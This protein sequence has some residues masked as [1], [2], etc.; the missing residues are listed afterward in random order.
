[1]VEA[2]KFLDHP[3]TKYSGFAGVPL[4]NKEITQKAAILHQ[5]LRFNVCVTALQ[6]IQ[7]INF[8]QF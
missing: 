3:C 6:E 7:L 2:E 8:T 4:Q 5:G 1:M